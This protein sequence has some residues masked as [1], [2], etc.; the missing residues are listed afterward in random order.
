MSTVNQ[1]KGNTSVEETLEQIYREASAMELSP[2]AHGEVNKLIVST[3]QAGVDWALSADPLEGFSNLTAAR[4]S[5]DPI[6]YE[7]LDGLK[8]QFVHP[9]MGTLHGT[10]KR[11]KRCA[12]DSFYGWWD[13]ETDSVYVRALCPAWSGSYGWTLW[14]EGEIPS[15]CKT[16]DQLPLGHL[17]TGRKLNG[18][19]G[20]YLLC[21]SPDEEDTLVLWARDF[22]WT[23]LQAKF[24]EVITDHG[25]LQKPE[26]K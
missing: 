2:D 25:P 3:F 16:A 24:W 4:K 26:V 5:G 7:K 10:L 18:T 17:F 11:D 19:P 13:G 21:T 22:T 14:V 9:E 23:K 6:D 12:P 15:V 8:V 20:E 1:I